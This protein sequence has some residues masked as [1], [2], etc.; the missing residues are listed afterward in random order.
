MSG[1]GGAWPR[2]TGGRARS[3]H[4]EA[5]WR[6]AGEAAGGRAVGG[7]RA[8]QSRQSGVGPAREFR[9]HGCR[10]PRPRRESVGLIVCSMCAFRLCGQIGIREVGRGAGAVPVEAQSTAGVTLT[11]ISRATASERNVRYVGTSYDVR[12]AFV[13]FIF[14]VFILDLDKQLDYQSVD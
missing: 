8:A 13:Y 1:L 2:G 9:T 5:T 7:L 3:A 10:G 14:T 4:P 12:T 11:A 6:V